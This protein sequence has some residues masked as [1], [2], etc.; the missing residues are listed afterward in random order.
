MAIR[1][2]MRPR[3]DGAMR[4][5]RLL[6]AVLPLLLGLAPLATAT[7]ASAAGCPS[8]AA[9]VSKADATHVT[10]FNFSQGV[11]SATNPVSTPYQQS[12]QKGRLSGTLLSS[13][14]SHVFTTSAPVTL[15]Y[16]PM[17]YNIAAGSIFDLGCAGQSKGAPLKPS[18]YLEAG[19]IEAHDPRGFSG[20]VTTFEGLYG[21]IPGWLSALQ[22]SVVRTPAKTISTLYEFV[23][24]SDM[25]TSSVRGLTAVKVIGVGHINVTPYAGPRIGTCRHVLVADLNSSTNAAAYVGLA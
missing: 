23:E 12:P 8:F 9:Y 14:G 17:T 11:L 19:R 18:V 13:S 10:D 7:V 22:F 3:G 15:H 21:A 20:A 4:K 25:S 24:S 6:F 2:E 1:V 5:L 16:G